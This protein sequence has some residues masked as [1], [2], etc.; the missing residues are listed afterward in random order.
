MNVGALFFGVL[1]GAPLG[2]GIAFLLFGNLLNRSNNHGDSVGENSRYTG[3]IIFSSQ[4][5]KKLHKTDEQDA[6]ITMHTKYLPQDPRCPCRKKNAATG[7][8]GRR[9]S[10]LCSPGCS[11]GADS[12]RRTGI[13]FLHG[14]PGCPGRN[15][16][17]GRSDGPVRAGIFD[18]GSDHAR[19][20]GAGRTYRP[21][22]AGLRKLR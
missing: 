3:G 20:F 4:E 2:L 7:K 8:T 10:S 16:G 1:I 13:P 15:P 6:Y 9:G 19:F 5:D 18:S 17:T 21:D 14:I 11:S 12:A 22:R